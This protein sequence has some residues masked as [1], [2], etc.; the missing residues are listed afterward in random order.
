VLLVD[1][2]GADDLVCNECYSADCRRS[3][4]LVKQWEDYFLECAAEDYPSASV[5]FIAASEMG[6]Q[7]A[8]HWE[9]AGYRKCPAYDDGWCPDFEALPACDGGEGEDE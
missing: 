5:L 8:A 7:K 1:S 4:A 3:V 9:P 6:T 2:D